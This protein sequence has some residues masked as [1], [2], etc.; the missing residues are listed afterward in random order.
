MIT[1]V[2]FVYNLL[3]DVELLEDYKE[4]LYSDSLREGEITF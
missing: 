3:G 4:S 1:I 2:N